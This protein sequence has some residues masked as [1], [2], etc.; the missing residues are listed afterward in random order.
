MVI[1]KSMNTNRPHQIF[2]KYIFLI[3]LKFH[4]VCANIGLDRVKPLQLGQT[5]SKPNPYS[6]NPFLYQTTDNTSHIYTLYS[7]RHHLG[8]VRLTLMLQCFLKEMKPK[9]RTVPGEGLIKNATL[10]GLL[11]RLQDLK[12]HSHAT[13]SPS[14]KVEQIDKMLSVLDFYYSFCVARFQGQTN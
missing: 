12:V 5:Y 13:I 6:L 10:T 9:F 14:R 1:S 8:S 3:L 4:V 11:G 7:V 2:A